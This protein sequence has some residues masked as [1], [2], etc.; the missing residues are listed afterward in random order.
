MKVKAVFWGIGNTIAATSKLIQE[1]TSSWERLKS[2]DMRDPKN[3]QQFIDS[4]KKSIKGFFSG[5]LPESDA[6]KAANESFRNQG[7]TGRPQSPTGAAS[8]AG[9]GAGFFGRLESAY[10]LPAGLLDS[11]WKQES[12]RGAN[13]LSSKGAMGHFQF[14]P[15]TAEQYGLKDP[16]DLYESANAAAR[17]YSDL[18]KQNGGDLDRALAGYNWGQGNLQKYGLGKA[19]AETRGYIDEVKSRMPSINQT[20]QITV[21]GAG[22]PGETA[23]AIA[24][25]QTRVNG[26]LVRN[27]AGVVQ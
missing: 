22:N 21:N 3:A 1:F 16:N 18:L 12:G 15:K 10:G 13:M 8:S 17:M 23:R 27:F 25:E 26:D 24:G 5:W 11:V 7:G 14:M 4:N 6:E 19:P 20:T 2:S 9:Q